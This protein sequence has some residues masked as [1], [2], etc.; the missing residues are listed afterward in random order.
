L[1]TLI[2]KESAPDTVDWGAAF[3][4]VLYGLLALLLLVGFL[5]SIWGLFTDCLLKARTDQGVLLM[6]LIKQRANDQV[7]REHRPGSFDWSS[8]FVLIASFMVFFVMF[9]LLLFLVFEFLP[10]LLKKV[11]GWVK[12]SATHRI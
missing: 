12:R 4:L 8:V 9:I 7:D 10:R 11:V 2:R 6:P 3:T 5:A 1:W